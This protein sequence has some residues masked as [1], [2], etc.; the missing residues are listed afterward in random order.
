[1]WPD[2]S[3]PGGRL[4][5]AA[6]RAHSGRRRVVDPDPMVAHQ[7]VEAEIGHHG[8]RDLVDL[9]VERE[10]RDDLVAVDNVALLVDGE[11]AVAVAVE[12][13]PEVEAAVEDG[14]LQEREVGRAAADIDVRAVGRV[15]DRVDLRA[16]AANA[17]ARGPSTRR[18]RSR[19]RC[20]AR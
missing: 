11:H 12:G 3:R 18:S 2:C 7:R 14:A 13:D 1:M 6:P 10:D 16:A 5:A 15:A 8:D 9:L 20:A 19:R 17:A 4:R